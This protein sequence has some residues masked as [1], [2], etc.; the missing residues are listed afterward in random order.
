MADIVD[1][2]SRQPISH[3]GEFNAEL[4]QDL[5]RYSEGG[6]VTE[7]EIRRR[8]QFDDS[9]GNLWPTM[10]SCS[11]PSLIARHSESAVGPISVKKVSS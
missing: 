4:V 8:Y 9:V 7:Q 5:A 10:K 1:L 2:R 3:E 6:L 11:Q